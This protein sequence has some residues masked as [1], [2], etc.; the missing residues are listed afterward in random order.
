MS[1]VSRRLK[2]LLVG[3]ALS[4]YVTIPA[5][6][7][8]DRILSYFPTATVGDFNG[9][10]IADAIVPGRGGA[11]TS[12]HLGRSD[13]EPLHL[14]DLPSGYLSLPWNDANA[15]V[16]SGDFNGDGR[17]DLLLQAST[18]SQR[19]A[20]LFA[21][22]D[23]RFDAVSVDLDPLHLGL[24]WSA[25]Q[26]TLS[27]GDFDGDGRADVLVRSL[28]GASAHTAV[29]NDGAGVPAFGPQ[30]W[31]DGYLGRTWN[32]REVATYSGDFNGDQ[33]ADLLMQVLDDALIDGVPGESAYAL[34]FADRNGLFT[35]IDAV[36]D[37]D[38]LGAEW[39]R[40]THML[41]V[42][43]VDGDGV[44]DAVLRARDPKGTNYLM[45]GT[46]RG[47]R[48]VAAKWTGTAT[49]RDAWGLAQQ[50]LLQHQAM[51]SG[52]QLDSPQGAG[53]AETEPTIQTMSFTGG[54]PAVGALAG[55]AGV[56]GG[57][58]SYSIPIVVPPGRAGMQPSV[59]IGYSS[60]GG[61]GELGMGWSLGVGSGISRCG[62]IAAIAGESNLGVTL[63]STDR[64]CLDGQRLVAISG[65]YGS[66][67]TVYRTE[68]ES[69][70]RVEQ[71]GA[72]FSSASSK[73]LVRYAD[74]RIAY[75]GYDAQSVFV[76]A[77]QSVPSRWLVTRIEDPATNSLIFSYYDA[78]GEHYVTQ[79]RYTGRGTTAGDRKVDFIWEARPDVS[80]SWQAGGRTEQA[81][82]L[83]QITTWVGAQAVREYRFSYA[84]D[85]AATQRSLLGSVEECAYSGATL[86]CLPQTNF[87]WQAAVTSFG[88]PGTVT[89]SDTDLVTSD[90]KFARITI[91]NP[92]DP[93]PQTP[94]L[95]MVTERDN[96]TVPQPYEVRPGASFIGA[97]KR[98]LWYQSGTSF[99][100]MLQPASSGVHTPT[101]FKS[102]DAPPG[103][104]WPDLGMGMWEYWPDY[105]D[106]YADM[107][108]D[109][110]T[111]LLSGTVL[112]AV[113]DA[114]GNPTSW[115]SN[116]MSVSESGMDG[117]LAD[118]DGDGKTD[119]ISLVDVDPGSA[120]NRQVK[121][122]RNTTPSLNLA[123]G[124]SF[125]FAAAVT[126]FDTPESTVIIMGQTFPTA[127]RLQQVM[128]LDGDGRPDILYTSFQTLFEA[129]AG[130]PD[131]VLLNRTVGSNVSFVSVAAPVTDPD[132][133]FIWAD[134]NGDGLQDFLTQGVGVNEGT[135]W[136]IRI[137]KGGNSFAALQT[138]GLPATQ[139]RALRIGDIDNDGKDEVFVPLQRVATMF[140]KDQTFMDSE[141]QWQT[142]DLCGAAATNLSPEYAE[143]DYSIYVYAPYRIVEAANGSLT[144]ID[145][146][147]RF[148]APGAGFTLGDA[149]GDGLNDIVWSINRNQVMFYAK[150]GDLIYLH[151]P[152]TP[153]TTECS[154]TF[155]YYGNYLSVAKQVA[156]DLMTKVT[157]GLGREAKWSYAPLS[158]DSAPTLSDGAP[159]YQAAGGYSD[160]QHF[161]F[162]STMYVVA[163]FQT[164]H[165]GIC[166]GSGLA[167]CNATWST[168]KYGY[169]EAMYN[170]QG[171]G[172]QGFRTIIEE[173]VHREL[174]TTTTFHQKFPFAGR[175]ETSTTQTFAQVGGAGSLSSVT[176]IW[177]SAQPID[178][179]TTETRLTNSIAVR[180]ELDPAYAGLLISTTTMTP[181]YAG[182]CTSASVET[183]TDQFGTR[184]VMI[185]N[186]GGSTNPATTFTNDFGSNW[187][188][189]RPLVRYTRTATTTDARHGQALTTD[190]RNLR[191]TL[192]YNSRR[193]VLTDSVE[194]PVV[195]AALKRTMTYTYEDS[196]GHVAFGNLKT[197]T[198]GG[199]AGGTYVSPRTTTTGWSADGYFPA[200]VTNPHG[201]VVTTITDA[202]HGQPTQVTDPNAVDA[203]ASYDAFGRKSASWVEDLP[204]Q[205][206][207]YALCAGCGSGGRGAYTVTT[208]QAGTPTTTVTYDPLNRAIDSATQGFTAG[209][210]VYGRTRFDAAGRTTWQREPD[211]TASNSGPRTDFV[212]D[213]LDR[214][215]QKTDA[216]GLVTST[217]FE[218]GITHVSATGD[219][220]TQTAIQE[221]DSA[222]RLIT[223]IDA[224]ANK[225]HFRYDA[226]GNPVRIVDGIGAVV[227]ATYNGL[228]QKIALN[229]PDLGAWS[230]SYNV[231][232]EL[233]SQ[234]DAKAK[235][236]TFTYDGLGR[237]TSRIEPET[238]GSCTTTW[239]YDMAQYGIGKPASVTQCGGYYE[240]Y[241]YD[242]KGRLTNLAQV[243]DL[244]LYETTT[245]YD[246]LGRVDTIWYPVQTSIGSPTIPGA[247]TNVQV[248][249]VYSLDG[250]HTVSWSPPAGGATPT[251]YKV[252][253]R[254]L[255]TTS[256]GTA[257][258][259]SATTFSKAYTLIAGDYE[260]KVNACAGTNCSAD[261]AIVWA[262]VAESGNFMASGG[263]MSMLMG[264]SRFGVTQ[265]YNAQG[266]LEKVQN[267]NTSAVYWTAGNLNAYGAIQSETFGNGVASS[268][269][270]QSG[271]PFVTGI[272]SSGGAQALT[273][274]W[275]AFGQL[276]NRTDSTQGLDEDFTYDLLNR[277][278]TGSLNFSGGSVTTLDVTYNAVGNILSKLDVSGTKSYTYPAFNAARPHAVTAAGGT[279]YAYDANG[280]MQTRAGSPITWTVANL[281]K[282]ID[283]GAN[284]AEFRYGPNRARFQQQAKLG[285]RTETTT[286][287]GSLYE[288]AAR[289]DRSRLEY[290]YQVT[291]GGMPVARV[292][293]YSDA[294]P[295]RT[296]YLHRDHLG[297]IDAVSNSS[298]VVPT[299]GRMSFD[300]HGSRR[301][302]N[303]TQGNAWRHLLGYAVSA[304]TIDGLREHTTR[305][306]TDHEML[307]G[308]GLTHM[309]GRVYDPGLGRFLS[310][311]PVFQFPTNT[312]SLNPYSYVLNSPLTLTDPTGLISEGFADERHNAVLYAL[313]WRKFKSPAAMFALTLQI[314]EKDAS[315]IGRPGSENGV[316]GAFQLSGFGHKGSYR[317][318][319]TLTAMRVERALQTMGG[320]ALVHRIDRVSGEVLGQVSV[321]DLPDNAYLAVNGVG[322]ELADAAGTARKLAR[323]D[324]YSGDEL[325]LLHN[326]TSGFGSDIAES[327][328]DIFSFMTASGY[329][330]NAAA[331]GLAL[332]SADADGRSLQLSGHSQGAAIVAAGVRLASAATLGGLGA[333][334]V[335]LRSGPIN[336][337]LAR[338]AFAR[339]GVSK[340]NVSTRG[341]NGDFVYTFLGFNSWNPLDYA[342]SVIQSPCLATS[343]SPH[344]IP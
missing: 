94:P 260:F 254:R 16:H 315:A 292:T 195:G 316:H 164:T 313:Q 180:K 259:V 105:T 189:C 102:I 3:A 143:Q 162:T 238:G 318:L 203:Y 152:G 1:V 286:Y 86:H 246:S 289:S 188:V 218:G 239:A 61:N 38:A 213:M 52:K 151:S 288:I 93:D 135:P 250:A 252:Y 7:D 134:L 307:D 190:T 177:G 344:S 104:D 206:I 98:E 119:A 199:G 312:Q 271:T 69:Y 37:R 60:R 29:L 107:N 19:S 91:N 193:Q 82:R 62:Q 283:S 268:R 198:I 89:A 2:A 236:S 130:R 36:W 265:T 168:R 309:N 59:S 34:A 65:T 72:A 174:R 341:S 74:G 306:F 12:I 31:A 83:Q 293:E 126:A 18:A 328:R 285:S 146:G 110:K 166:A 249:P 311:D 138:P 76:P 157:D 66:S 326:P 186:A 247:P 136:Q 183:T 100:R 182:A 81:K 121:L 319:R 145:T 87:E 97:G 323:E 120:V 4:F 173:D 243:V 336:S 171:R 53:K 253:K 184:T 228:G 95:E 47:F 163:D 220:V 263:E 226:L 278:R 279:N 241:S 27:V 144:A 116:P 42:G 127:A 85:S 73:F 274:Q 234:V 45:L 205:N 282:R 128:D 294:T 181:T 137:N 179:Y 147:I 113:V 232:G 133:K 46:S 35:S 332:Y 192:T 324:Q 80:S 185:G 20:V 106:G 112:S 338:T 256:W 235:T 201:H 310:V 342:W 50:G 139:K 267:A 159:M 176:N 150:P 158:S 108:N 22:T 257:T 237:M 240:T 141:G 191:Q 276:I 125:S 67:G 337:Q 132:D 77:N 101:G 78:G 277:L 178:A 109:G 304:A 99:V 161:Y 231:L 114:Q 124:A 84:T 24:P 149:N 43:D 308:V 194:D 44:A 25:S 223:A 92:A 187:I 204:V 175:V 115:K 227:T 296:E 261:S 343:C 200:T 245:S 244:Y 54:T 215:K 118:F 275:N 58:A 13:A 321:R 317:S 217:T 208:T 230:Y 51:Q 322:E 314:M 305:G 96:N 280:N 68:L 320:E 17:D 167:D 287:V 142:E 229:D 71:S 264:E 169:R 291:A 6:A 334:D 214:V 55:E 11:D 49:A 251:S 202:K 111:D 284:Y 222:G 219:G 131:K 248:D 64:L 258:T 48:E 170:N 117:K 295:S 330:K 233:L 300:A 207:A 281:P 221:T 56:S 165:H 154:F 255:P 172:F 329:T 9:D 41:R 339:A 216:K 8:T 299:D 298:G 302:G 335:T 23:G 331:V 272:S 122:S 325:Y 210:T 57:A 290:R 14:Q 196:A 75:Y 242:V 123:D 273:Y 160:D 270:F 32:G 148:N 140:M 155:P 156:P 15:R 21:A 10:G 88:L 26:S 301:A 225:T 327:A 224:Y 39:S 70:V 297:S 30:A 266:Y 33:R 90:L 79:I 262:Q 197:V 40:Y 28:D 212:Y 129:P 209:Q 211:F 103:A 340:E 333:V 269:T 153:C 5:T 63:T 303:A